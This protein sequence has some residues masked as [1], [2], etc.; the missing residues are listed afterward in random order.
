[1]V[2]SEELTCTSIHPTY[3]LGRYLTPVVVIILQHGLNHVR[4]T[5]VIY[6]DLCVYSSI[7]EF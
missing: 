2:L 1:M 6:L 3:R 7:L 5:Y 4:T